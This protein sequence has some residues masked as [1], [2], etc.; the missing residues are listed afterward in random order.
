MSIFKVWTN[1]CH[2]LTELGKP[3]K[4]TRK[5]NYMASG[6]MQ[7]HIKFIHVARQPG[8]EYSSKDYIDL[9]RQKKLGSCSSSK[10]QAST[11]ND[12]CFESHHYVPLFTSLFLSETSN[13]NDLMLSYLTYHQTKLTLL[14]HVFQKTPQS[15]HQ[16]AATFNIDFEL[17]ESI[18]GT[19]IIRLLAS[20]V[21]CRTFNLLIITSAKGCHF[22]LEMITLCTVVLYNIYE[23]ACCNWN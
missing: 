3:M 21:N 20:W 15:F 18:I 10:S 4:I 2:N 8:Q 13:A 5:T 6:T 12:N 17:Q 7:M 16:L 9:W 1:H 11:A 14:H 22:I 23:D 19:N